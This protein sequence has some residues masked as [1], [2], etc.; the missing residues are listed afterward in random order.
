MASSSSPVCRWE[1]VKSYGLWDSL[2]VLAVPW[3]AC[4]VHAIGLLR[5][6]A[7]DTSSG[8]GVPSVW[9]WLPWMPLVT[10]SV[11]TVAFLTN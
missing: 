1:S 3:I 9:R 2:L 5:A 6:R 10:A 4:T 8:L 7:R 11:F